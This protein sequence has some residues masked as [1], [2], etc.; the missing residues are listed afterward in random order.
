[1]A[2]AAYCRETQQAAPASEG[3]FVRCALESLA[4]K[5]A[6][7]F[8]WLV[9]MTSKPLDT[10]H[11]VGGGSRN[12]LLNQF[13]A[14]ACQ[15]RVVAGLLPDE[16]TGAYMAVERYGLLILFA[17]LWFGIIDRLV[18]PLAMQILRLYSRILL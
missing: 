3:Q 10:I 5:Y 17:M 14:D 18:L 15:R 12:N 8:E 16:L 7:V 13:T 6:I 2:I 1:L 11:V 9:A 4:L